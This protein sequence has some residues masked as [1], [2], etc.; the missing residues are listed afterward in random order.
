MKVINW[1]KI[2]AQNGDNKILIGDNRKYKKCMSVNA[3]DIRSE[4]GINKI[5]VIITII[6]LLVVCWGIFF[7]ILFD[8]TNTNQ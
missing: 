3:L 6:I 5:A 8:N 2:N 1:Y 4:N 7:R